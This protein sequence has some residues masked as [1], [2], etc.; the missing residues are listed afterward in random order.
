MN[1]I[2]GA[3]LSVRGTFLLLFLG[4]VL[5]SYPV[6]SDHVLRLIQRQDLLLSL[7]LE[8]GSECEDVLSEIGLLNKIFKILTKGWTLRSSVSLVVME[9]IVVSCSETS[10][11]MCFCLRTF[12]PGLTL[13]GFEDVLDQVLQWVEVVGHLIGLGLALL[14]VREWLL[15]ESALST[16]LEVNG[17]ASVLWLRFCSIVAAVER[18]IGGAFH[19]FLQLDV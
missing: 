15:P 19:Y 11:V 17:G 8:E 9:E 1:E 7:C 2:H 10:R 5:V 12:P 16:T 3:F 13:N 6:L 14:R 18:W 4:L